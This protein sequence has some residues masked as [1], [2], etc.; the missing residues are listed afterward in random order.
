MDAQELDFMAGLLCMDP[1]KRLTGPQCLAHPYLADLAGTNVGT[2]A[3]AE[4]AAAVVAMARLSERTASLSMRASYCG[5]GT[6]RSSLSVSAASSAEGGMRFRDSGAGPSD[7]GVSG[8]GVG[9]VA[10]NGSRSGVVEEAQ[11]T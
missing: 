3:A 4:A 7:G 11:T 5:E 2:A 10:Q 8:Q 9:Q 1:A 6:P